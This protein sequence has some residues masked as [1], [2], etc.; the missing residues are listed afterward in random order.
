MAKN[1]GKGKDDGADEKKIKELL[2]YEIEKLENIIYF[3]QEKEISAMRE[4]E[5]IL[6][7]QNDEQ[8]AIDTLTLDE[9]KKIIFENDGLKG[10]VSEFIEQVG[11][12]E[13]EIEDLENFNKQK[14]IVLKPM[15]NSPKIGKK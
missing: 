13:K 9:S 4:L 14:R 7:K 10:K 3:E 1:K 2:T 12:L 15:I 11:R 8:K 6:S 5:K